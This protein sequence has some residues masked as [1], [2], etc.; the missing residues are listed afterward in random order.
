ME[1][2][3]VQPK[4]YAHA[5]IPGVCECD[6]I[7]VRAKSSDKCPYRRHT[8]RRGE[9][10]VKTEAETGVI[11]STSQGI[12]PEAEKG[13]EKVLPGAFRES[14]TLPTPFNFRL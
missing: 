9:G 4:R 10:H 1:D 2:G 14:V 11:T 12:P 5:V 3:I 6:L 8:G 13:K 7:Q